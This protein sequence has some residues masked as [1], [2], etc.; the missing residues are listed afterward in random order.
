MNRFL[1]LTHFWLSNA[2]F[3]LFFVC[4]FLNANRPKCDRA[5]FVKR[6]LFFLKSASSPKSFRKYITFY[7][8]YSYMFK[9]PFQDW[10]INHC[11][12]LHKM[13]Y[14]PSTPSTGSLSQHVPK[15]AT[16]ITDLINTAMAFLKRFFFKT[17]FVWLHWVLN[18]Q[19][20]SPLPLPPHPPAKRESGFIWGSVMVLQCYLGM[21]TE[22]LSSLSSVEMDKNCQHSQEM[23]VWLDHVTRPH[24]T[25]LRTKVHEVKML[26]VSKFMPVYN[27]IATLLSYIGQANT[28]CFFYRHHFTFNILVI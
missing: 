3:L 5:G 26:R 18:S 6:C 4:L 27:I 15:A 13:L 28:V 20:A 2:Y 21:K 25:P 16:V 17:V 10:T 23:I 1:V 9:F 11:N 8:Y 22:S 14:L 24:R 7:V 19:S 12:K